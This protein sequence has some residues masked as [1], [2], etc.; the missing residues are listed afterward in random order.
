MIITIDKKGD[1]LSVETAIR[2]NVEFTNYIVV[3]ETDTTFTI[4]ILD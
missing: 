1:G 3:S 4:K 2:P